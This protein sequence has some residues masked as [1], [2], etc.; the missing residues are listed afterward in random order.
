MALHICNY[1]IVQNG[2]QGRCTLA[3]NLASTF[4]G[5]DTVLYKAQNDGL[6]CTIWKKVELI[7]EY[8][9]K[10]KFALWQGKISLLSVQ[11]LAP[12][13]LCIL[14]CFAEQKGKFSEWNKLLCKEWPNFLLSYF[15]TSLPPFK[16]ANMRAVRKLQWFW[17]KPLVLFIQFVLGI[18]SLNYQS[19][20][21]QGS[22]DLNGGLVTFKRLLCAIWKEIHS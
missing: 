6:G 5:I 3:I 1:I 13:L 17:R 18:Q 16:D 8:E 7:R 2:H 12:I 21:Q 22:Q 15:F 19:W 20:P 4:I 11:G 10:I 14:R 9:W